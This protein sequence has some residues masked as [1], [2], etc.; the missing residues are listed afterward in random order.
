M[1]KK[2]KSSFSSKKIE[3]NSNLDKSINWKVI[4]YSIIALIC[5]YFMYKIDWM[6]IIPVLICIWLNQRALFSSRKESSE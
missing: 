2:T 3:I 6:F 5:I 4:L 1:K